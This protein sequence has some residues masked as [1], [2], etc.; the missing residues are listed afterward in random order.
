MIET[1]GMNELQHWLHTIHHWYQH[2]DCAAVAE[3]QPLIFG[4]PQALWQ[5]SSIPLKAKRSPAGLMPVC[6]N[7]SFIARRIP[8]RPCN[9]SIWLTVDSSSAP[10]NLS[11]TWSWNLGACYGCNSWWCWVL[12]ISTI[13]WV[14]N[15]N[16]THWSM[17]MYVL[18]R[19]MLG[20]MIKELEIRC[21]DSRIEAL[22]RILPNRRQK[23]SELFKLA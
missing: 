5:L 10:L 7:L 1:Y 13:K 14:E 21:A 9:I 18:W 6:V 20:T 12:N 22:S 8:R 15:L 23:K 3:L 17:R 11:V 19:F 16:L 2:S 4:A